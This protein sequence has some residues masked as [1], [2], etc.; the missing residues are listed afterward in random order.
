MPLDE[1]IKHQVEILS[2]NGIE[3][4]ESCEGGVGHCFPE[5]TI[6]FHG[7]QAEGFKALAIAAQHGLRVSALRRFWSVIDGEP[8]GPKWEMT[9]Y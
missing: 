6:R 3:T 1:G 2:A 9:F 7:D 8:V 5:P 4:Y